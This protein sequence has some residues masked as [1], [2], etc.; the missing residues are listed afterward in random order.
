MAAHSSVLAWRIPRTEEPGGYSPKESDTAEVTWHT[1]H[2]LS[3]LNNRKIC[4]LSSGAQKSKIK[5]PVRLAPSEV[6]RGGS[7][8]SSPQA[9]V[10]TWPSSGLL[11]VQ[12]HP[13]LDLG[14]HLHV[15]FSQ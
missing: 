4:P 3:S 10:V 12:K 1:H 5:E 15:E 6:C 14:L 2:Q 13:H 8:P 11:G 7:V 9:L